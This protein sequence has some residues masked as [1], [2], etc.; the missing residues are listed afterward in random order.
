M[1]IKIACLAFLLA[2]LIAAPAVAQVTT[3]DVNGRV[4]DPKGLAVLG[5]KVT[6]S[7][8]D[9]GFSRETT[10]NDSGE[11]AVTLLPPGTYKV[12]I[13]KDGFATTVYEKVELAVGAK[14]S[15]DV[16]LKLG[17]GRETVT[18]NEQPPLIESTRS[19]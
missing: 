11:F 7:N 18:V 12:T 19:D 10:T 14:Q 17:A 15:L 9:T 16:S 13:E 8:P 3:A 6:I 2:E 1:R 5:A 4:L